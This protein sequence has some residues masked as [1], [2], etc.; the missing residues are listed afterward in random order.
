[1]PI[2]MGNCRRI[3]IMATIEELENRIAGI[4]KRNA[5]VALDKDWEGSMTRRALLMLFTYAS[6]SL[7]FL[8]LG[9]DRPFLN[10]VV[11]TLGF[12]LSTLTLPWFKAA[13]MRLR[14]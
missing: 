5:K 12:M 10:A 11:P 9:I 6:V 7:Y 14:Q 13:W 3:P 1:M 8:F 4:E 2:R